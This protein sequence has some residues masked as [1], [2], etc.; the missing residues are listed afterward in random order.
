MAPIGTVRSEIERADLAVHVDMS[1]QR[2][3]II[4]DRIEQIDSSLKSLVTDFAD[5]RG[6]HISHMTEIKI[7]Q[8]AAMN[9]IRSEQTAQLQDLFKIMLG[10]GASTIAILVSALIA[11]MIS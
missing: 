8:D 9:A 6:E 4:A 3:A 2:D 11:I 1:R 5:F 7:S 10:V